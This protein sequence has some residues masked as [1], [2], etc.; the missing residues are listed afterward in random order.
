[1]NWQRIEDAPREVQAA[2]PAAMQAWPAQV[3]GV[4]VEDKFALY[5]LWNPNF[6]Q[7]WYAPIT[8]PSG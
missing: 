8:E 6:G 3:V 7:I 2:V 1:M 4:T 5:L